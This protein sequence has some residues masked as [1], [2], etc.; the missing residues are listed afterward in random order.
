MF[1]KKRSQIALEYTMV[2]FIS[3]IMIGGV[4]YYFFSQQSSYED[5]A[6]QAKVN[7]IGEKISRYAEEAYYSTGPYRKTLEMELPQRINK[8]YVHDDNIIVFQAEGDNEYVYLSGAPVY[9]Y[10]LKDSLHTGKIIVEKI[11]DRPVICGKAPCSCE[12]NE[13]NCTDMIDNDCD[14]KIDGADTDCCP[15]NDGDG[16]TGIDY[17][18]SE[19]E[20]C[21]PPDTFADDCNDTRTDVNPGMEEE[22]DAVDHDCDGNPRNGDAC[23]FGCYIEDHED[24][25]GTGSCKS[26]YKA[27]LSLAEHEESHVEEPGGVNNYPYDLCCKEEVSPSVD[28]SWDIESS[29][30][31]SSGEKVLGLHRNLPYGSHVENGSLSN[32]QHSLCGELTSGLTIECRVT[33]NDDCNANEIIGMKTV[34]NTHVGKVGSHA[35]TLCCGVS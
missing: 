17:S 3:L 31:C 19:P 1:S 27:I 29:K 6:V 25:D 35:L 28:V 34:E 32:F 14:G 26:G 24:Q 20:W 11:N 18:G 22:C 13:T 30:T 4:T 33:S 7:S 2:V 15:D 9:G 16:Y 23:N 21:Q 8:I 12:E 5:E 10:V